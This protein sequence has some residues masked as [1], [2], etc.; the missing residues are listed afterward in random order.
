M[1]PEDDGQPPQDNLDRLKSRLRKDTLAEKLA[2]ARIEAG[3]G[4]PRPAL[5]KVIDGRLEELRR[6]YE[7]VP[8]RKA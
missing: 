2:A 7:S 5:R 3:T 6:T 1:K 4:D 8:D